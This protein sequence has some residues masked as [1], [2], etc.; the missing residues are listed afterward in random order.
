[1]FLLVLVPFSMIALF[2]GSAS[3]SLFLVVFR[4]V[5]NILMFPDYILVKL[6]NGFYLGFYSLI[7][8]LILYPLLIE[9]I[10]KILYFK[11][12]NTNQFPPKK[13]G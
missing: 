11:I 13:E 1:M 3:S 12:N 10:I 9:R 4:G 2:D 8:T 6:F 7:P 5:A